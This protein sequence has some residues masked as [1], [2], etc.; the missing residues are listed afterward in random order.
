MAPSVSVKVLPIKV[1]LDVDTTRNPDGRLTVSVA[2]LG[3]ACELTL[4]IR[5][6]TLVSEV[7]QVV[8]T[9]LVVICNNGGGVV[10]PG[11]T[12]SD[13]AGVTVAVSPSR[14]AIAG[15]VACAGLGATMFGMT[16][17]PA[18]TNIRTRELRVNRARIVLLVSK[19]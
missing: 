8:T 9:L 13:A 11:A 3:V 14:G 2:S 6:V 16:S 1:P 12:V 10:G 17:T 18:R 19:Q 15:G 5:S 7:S 4:V